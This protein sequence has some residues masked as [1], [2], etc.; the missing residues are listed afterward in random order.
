MYV[1]VCT[2]IEGWRSTGGHD[3]DTYNMIQRFCADRMIAQ[4]RFMRNLQVRSVDANHEDS[5]A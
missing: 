4:A 3:A 2:Y 1:Y 5:R